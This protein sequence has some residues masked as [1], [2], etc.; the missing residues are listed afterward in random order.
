MA[1]NPYVN[2]VQLADGTVLMDISS[3]TVTAA[4]VLSGTTAHDATGAPI[5]GTYLKVGSLWSTSR[6]VKPESV[7]GFGTWEL[8]RKSEFTWRE[9]GQ[10]TWGEMK[11]DTWGH[12]HYRAVVYVWLRIA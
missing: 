7:L 10:H 9:A 11:A 1:N 5:T 4:K 6:N 8:I 3:D 12:Q 2:K